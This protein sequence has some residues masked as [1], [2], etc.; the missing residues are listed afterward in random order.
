MAHQINMFLLLFGALQGGLLSLWFLRRQN[1]SIADWFFIVFMIIIG[2]QLTLKVIT[3]SWLMDH[4]LIPYILSYKL[5]YLVGPLLFLYV[6]ARKH[7]FFSTHDLL[8]FIPFLVFTTIALLTVRASWASMVDFHP[9]IHAALQVFLIASYAYYSLRLG[10]VQLKDFLLLVTLAEV[11]IAITLAV[12]YMNYLP[13]PHVCFLFIVLTILIYWISYK[14]ISEPDIFVEVKKTSIVPLGFFRKNKYVNSTLTQKE[15]D[16]IEASLHRLLQEE[17]VFLD[18]SLTL[19]SLAHKIGTSRHHLSQVL[20]ERMHRSYAEHM[21]HFRLEEASRRLS[22]GSNLPFT[23]AAIALD[24]GFS[25]VSH[26]NDIFKKRFGMTPSQFRG[27]H[28]QEGST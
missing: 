24:A 9:C 17:K 4:A 8:H 3:K 23:I 26:F 12:M 13:F 21:N 18:S 14:A 7:H 27:Q 11:L 2:L 20:N 10:N 28:F 19:D 25:S 22:D 5:P 16:S 15:A 1:K 6:K